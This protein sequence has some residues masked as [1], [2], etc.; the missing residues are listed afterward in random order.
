VLRYH[1]RWTTRNNAI[2]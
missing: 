1:I 2:F